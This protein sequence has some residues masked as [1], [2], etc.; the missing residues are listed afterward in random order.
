MVPAPSNIDG[1]SVVCFTPIDRRHRPTGACEHKVGGSQQ[2]SFAAVAICR[3][4]GDDGFYLF[5]CDE[6]WKPITDTWHQTLDDAIKQ[7]EFEYEGTSA[8]WQRH[9]E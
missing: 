9:G 5:Y 3:F 1:A 6:E 7:A 8:T 2:P 4:D